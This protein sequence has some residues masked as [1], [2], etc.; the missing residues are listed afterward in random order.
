MVWKPVFEWKAA[1]SL[2]PRCLGAI[3][4]EVGCSVSRSK[5]ARAGCR[6]QRHACWHTRWL[7]VVCL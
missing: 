6:L 4:R 3:H 7:W 2:L 5:R 1:E